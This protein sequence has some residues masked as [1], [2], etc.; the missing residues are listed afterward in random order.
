MECQFMTVPQILQMYFYPNT[1]VI[2]VVLMTMEI[3]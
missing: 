2:K 1:A 3:F